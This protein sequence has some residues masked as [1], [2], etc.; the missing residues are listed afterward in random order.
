MNVSFRRLIPVL[1]VL[2]LTTIPC[3]ARAQGASRAADLAAIGKVAA[4][5]SARYVRGD[6]QGMA[7]LYTEN[8][9]IFPG[10]RPIMRGRAAIA[11]YWTLPTGTK[12]IEHKT[13][14]DSV[15]IVGNTAYDYGTFRARNEKD[16]QPGNV[17][18]GKY[19]IV[20]Q[21]QGDGRWLMHLDIWNGSPAP[22]P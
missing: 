7:Q 8:G 15:I 6:A 13:T 22:Q 19:V 11:E 5:F 20:W 9:A 2:A 12:V 14:A 21:R 18:Y 3:A 17:G 4:D 10:G 1:T 16:G